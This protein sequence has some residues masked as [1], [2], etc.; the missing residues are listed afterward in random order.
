M[1][2]SSAETEPD[3]QVVEFEIVIDFDDTS[4]VGTARSRPWSMPAM[5]LQFART[6]TSRRFLDTDRSS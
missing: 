3:D 6:A 2:D 1:C 5:S 4:S